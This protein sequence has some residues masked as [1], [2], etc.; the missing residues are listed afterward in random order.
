MEFDKLFS[1]SLREL[2]VQQ[3]EHMILAGKLKTGEK[4]PSERQLAETMQVSRAVV[5]G[6]IS[7][8]EK[9]GFLI[10]KPRIGT[11]VADYRR[12]GT[13]D[14]LI[15]IMKYNGGRLRDDEIRS[16][17]EVRL[18]LGTLA[19]NLFLPTATDADIELL[20]SIAERIKVSELTSEACAAAFDFHH[21]LAVLSGN[22]LIP[23]IFHSFK[24][25]VLSLWER[26]CALYGTE[27]LYNNTYTLW[28][29]LSERDATG[30]VQW[31][32]ISIGSSTHGERPIYY[33]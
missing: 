1:P 31:I 2:F 8:L 32:E 25:P 21:E 11:F 18:A 15:A 10:I 17:L 20:H 3:L 7:D 6:G 22:T 13:L 33:E 4:L 16:I 12:N 27:A 23:L 14:T 29:C 19:V 9:K 24:V 26:F 28:R 5:N 30:A